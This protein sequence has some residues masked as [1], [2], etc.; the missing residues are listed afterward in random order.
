MNVFDMSTWDQ[1]RI[2]IYS[3]DDFWFEYE[4]WKIEKFEYL[5]N[6][7]EY[8]KLLINISIQIYSRKYYHIWIYLNIGHALTK[9][10]SAWDHSFY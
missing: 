9:I 3:F 6:I 2:G 7:T 5:L 1:I 8:S 10:A 4:Y